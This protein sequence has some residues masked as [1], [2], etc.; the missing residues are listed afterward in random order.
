ML[1]CLIILFYMKTGVS[2]VMER[3]YFDMS[4]EWKYPSATKSLAFAKYFHCFIVERREKTWSCCL[5]IY[6]NNTDPLWR[7][8]FFSF[9]IFCLEKKTFVEL[10]WNYQE[11]HYTRHT[12]VQYMFTYILYLPWGSSVN[13]VRPVIHLSIP[14]PH[15]LPRWLSFPLWWPED[16][17]DRR[18]C[19]EEGMT[20]AW[21]DLLLMAALVDW[22]SAYGPKHSAHRVK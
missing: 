15:I 1:W 20:Q 3:K 17:R 11:H 9:F 5:I 18:R 13:T 16:V 10:L 12:G 7:L 21:L 22:H 14:F 2:A 4:R 19:E 6:C 8:F